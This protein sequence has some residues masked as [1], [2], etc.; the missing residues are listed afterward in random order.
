VY[1]N[2]CCHRHT[3]FMHLNICSGVILLNTFPSLVLSPQYFDLD[4]ET[5]PWDIISTEHDSD[6]IPLFPTARPLDDSA[7]SIP[8]TDRDRSNRQTYTVQWTNTTQGPIY[9]FCT[10]S[11]PTSVALVQCREGCPEGRAIIL[12]RS[13]AATFDCLMRKSLLPAFQWRWRTHCK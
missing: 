5:S 10:T 13:S 12:H 11:A 6:P 4:Y 2:P 8:L 1:I 3:S 7:M 9:L